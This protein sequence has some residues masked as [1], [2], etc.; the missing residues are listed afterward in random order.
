MAASRTFSKKFMRKITRASLR[1]RSFGTNTDWL[2][3]WLQL[4]S[5]QMVDLFG[6]ARITT[7]MSNLTSLL[8]VLAPLA[9]WHQSSLL[10]MVS[11]KLKLL[12]VLS[13]VTTECINRARRPQ[14]ILLHRYLLGLKVLSI[15]QS[16]MEMKNLRNLL[17]V[18]KPQSSKVLSKV[19]WQRI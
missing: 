10:L 13:L 19:S 4:A 15:V 5:S 12:T 8:K 17:K 16:S 11:L 9:L 3:I 7:V 1:L 2:M 6:L 14:Q 18:L